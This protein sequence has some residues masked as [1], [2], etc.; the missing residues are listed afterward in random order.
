MKQSHQAETIKCP[1]FQNITKQKIT[2]EGPCDDCVATALVYKTNEQRNKQIK[3]FC[4][5]KYQNCEVYR[6]INAAKY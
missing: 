2:C 6:M 4:Q 5:G 3:I 1:F